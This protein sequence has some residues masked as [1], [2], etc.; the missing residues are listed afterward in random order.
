M[1]TVSKS[2]K[3]KTLATRKK[4]A[5]LKK[6]ASLEKLC[7]KCGLCC[8]IKVGLTDGTYVIHP[9]AT[10]KYLRDDNTCAVYETRLSS[11]SLICFSREEMIQKDYILPEGCPYTHQRSGYRPAR[12]VSQKEYDEIIEKELESGNYNVLLVNRVF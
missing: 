6:N 3:R 2:K 11:D 1:K 9:T 12:V 5:F 8:H 10:C 7:R 4:E